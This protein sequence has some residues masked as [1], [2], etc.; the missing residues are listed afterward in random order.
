M[1]RA[2]LFVL[3]LSLFGCAGQSSPMADSAPRSEATATKSILMPAGAPAHDVA[4]SADRKLIRTGELRVS[5]DAFEPLAQALN[6]R[7]GELG[8]FVAD[9]DLNHHAGRVGYATLVVRVPADRFDDLLAWAESEVEVQ[10][11]RVDTADVTEQWVDVH[12]RIANNKRTE[13]R[14][15]RLLEMDTAKL[16]DVLAVEREL[17]RVRGEIESAEGRMRVLRDQVGLATLTLQVHVRDPFQPAVAQAYH[18]RLGSAFTGS[19]SALVDVVA[20]FGIVAVASLPW[21][22][23]LALFLVATFRVGRF[24]FR[25][26]R[27]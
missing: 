22:T 23:V 2:L 4:E 13:E 3:C 19:I 10:S 26:A 24:A 17:T 14:L 8:G 27:A 18:A 25:R 16:E 9:S 21:L 7:L 12:A 20:G 15:L 1:N 11:L 6:T 5:V